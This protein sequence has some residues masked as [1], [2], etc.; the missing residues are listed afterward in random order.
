MPLA[1]PQ[2]LYLNKLSFDA[3]NKKKDI[4]E[5]LQ[6]DDVVTIPSLKEKINQ[7]IIEKD[8]SEWKEWIIKLRQSIYHGIEY[9]QEEDKYL[10]G[11]VLED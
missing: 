4:P 5:K 11:K 9:V 7:F 10:E 2:G 1:P 8:D 6:F 3:Y